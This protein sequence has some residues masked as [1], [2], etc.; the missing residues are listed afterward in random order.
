MK[1]IV[2]FL[3]LLLFANVN[4]QA[5]TQS[6]YTYDSLFNVVYG[7]GI[8]YA[9]N[10]DTLLMDIYKPHGD[11]NCRRP[12]IV[13]VHGGSWIA[14]S[15]EDVDLVYL[16]RNLARKGWVVANINWR[17]GTHKTSNYTMYGLC[18]NTISAPCGYICDSS[19]IFRANFRG[20]QDT[21]GAIRFMKSRHMIDSSDVNNVFLA[22]ESAGGFVCLA[23]AFTDQLNEKPVDCFA[24][25]N[26]PTPDPDFATYGCNPSTISYA[27]PDLG[28]IDGT[29]HTG[30]YDAS[31]KGVGNFFGGMMDLSIINQLGDTPA[32]YLFHQ[33]S[34]VIVDYDYNVILGRISWECYAQ[35]NVCQQYY[36]YPRAYGSEGLRQYFVSLGSAAPLFTTDIV[37]NYSYMNNCFSNGHS[38]DNLQTRL[39]SMVNFFSPI[40]TAS[41]NDPLT[42]CQ[43]MGMTGLNSFAFSISPNPATNEISLQF[44]QPLNSAMVRIYSSVGNLVQEE[45]ISSSVQQLHLE[46]N[47]AD[48]CYF[49]SV[50]SGQQRSMKKII[51][52]K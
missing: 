24:I 26:A 6:N 10:T 44:S 4:A 3:F 8:D 7:T 29:L 5:Y 34:D 41:G 46:T 15:K 49:V 9:G 2:T 30:T 12:I 21:K 18:N 38:V 13:L 27:R 22:G 52:V 32:V 25:G 50:E 17:L 39:Q 33:G 20:M 37:S 35:S 23:A 47:L 40:I 14:G 19:E 48:G 51:I 28:S 1:T 31:V 43:A 42:N 36:F 11:G 16:S 45:I